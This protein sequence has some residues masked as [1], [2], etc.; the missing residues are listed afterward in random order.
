MKIRPMNAE[1]VLFFPI[2]TT[3]RSTTVPKLSVARNVRLAW[4]KRAIGVL[5]NVTTTRAMTDG[6]EMFVRAGPFNETIPFCLSFDGS[7]FNPINTSSVSD[8]LRCSFVRIVTRQV[9]LEC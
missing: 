2:P 6:H 3:V 7:E 9:W 8:I 4:G 5:Q 1:C